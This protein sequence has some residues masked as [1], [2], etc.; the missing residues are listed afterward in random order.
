MQISDM[1]AQYN[2]SSAT[3]ATA[4]VPQQGVQQLVSAVREMTVGNVF[5]GTVNDIKNGTVTLGLANGQTVQARIA[6]GVQLAVGQAMFFQVKSNDG[7]TVE[8]R[9]YTNGNLNNPTLLKAL[10]A[11]GIPAEPRMIDMVNSMMEEQMSIGRESL[12]DMARSISAYPDADIKSLVLMHKLDIPMSEEFIQQ[13]ENYKSDQAA[14][15]SQFDDVLES[16]GKLYQ[17]ENLSETEALE[18]GSR[19]YQV[20]KQ[21]GSLDASA[22]VKEGAQKGS[23]SPVELQ[24]GAILEGTSE[25]A[26]TE[27]TGTELAEAETIEETLDGVAVNSGEEVAS[28]ENAAQVSEEKTS[29]D[30]Q[31]VQYYARG[32]VG[33]LFTEGQMKD[34]SNLLK[35]FPQLAG[36]KLF[37]AEGNL[38]GN[39]STG[40][41]LKELHQALDEIM[42]LTGGSA[43]K[44]F[45]GK[46]YQK[47]LEYEVKQQWTLKPE[48]IKGDAVKHLY[49]KM[50]KQMQKMQ[51]LVQESGQSNTS[52]AKAVSN[53]QGN[54]EF[55]NQI[56]NAYHY[57]QI[58]LRMSNQNAHGDLFVYTNKSGVD[59]P[60]GELSAFLHLDMDN[61]GATDVSVRMKDRKVHTNFYLEDEKSYDL[62]EEHM[63][64]LMQRLQEKGYSCTVQ[65]E[66][67]F[68]KK[69][70][71]ED[72]M[73]QEHPSAGI[74]HRYSF[75][76]RA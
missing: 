23:W 10:D 76:M 50:E 20:L 6:A 48:E 68:R 71:V 1:L 47:V 66:N 24:E 36:S 74:L 9:P 31:G 42:G 26:A 41:F 28:E 14:I 70:L 19:I 12:M 5:E 35:E 27:I 62:I 38:N 46:E 37:T 17:N 61:L 33:A 21:D 16:I 75:D 49:E 40:A 15:T 45:S 67:Q 51:E 55:M 64:E 7:T 30:A 54:I 25:L 13:F 53:L 29:S 3:G 73:Q 8:I 69:N 22:I 2:R 11:A 18:L 52:L 56:N 57:V 59:R 65:V 63:A 39:L 43:K 4:T 72:F 32:S 44:L 34:F 60:D 58:P